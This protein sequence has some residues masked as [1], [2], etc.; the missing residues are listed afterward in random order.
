MTNVVSKVRISEDC[1]LA[2]RIDD[3]VLPWDSK[4]SVV[5]LHGLAES[6][7]TFRR[8][9]PHFADRHLVVRPDLR[10]YGEST[11]MGVDYVYSLKNLGRDVIHLLDALK[12][13]R[14]L[15]IGA[16]IGGTLAMHLA[17][18]Y[19]DRVIAFAA[20]GSP[21]SLTS[22][23]ER[24]PTWR[25]EIREHG[26]NAWVRETTGGRLGTSL[27]PQAIDWWVDLMSKTPQSTL[28]AFLRMVPTV[29]VSADLPRIRCPA[30][31]IT[32]TGSGLGTVESVRSWQQQIAD[33]TLEVLPGD[34]YH[35][36]ATDA[37][38]CARIVRE[39][40]DRVE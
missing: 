14:V 23:S 38:T 15:L 20:V 33:S 11:P 29:D 24:A 2:V 17:A 13:D 34:S 5:M 30:V 1:E 32:T 31:I 8:W 9:A 40:F 10:G 22:F 16:K 18:T 7:E 3:Y 25:K 6:G 12:L 39:Y 26:V 4:A 21:V 19:P 35:V 37:D 28:E 36:A 27:P